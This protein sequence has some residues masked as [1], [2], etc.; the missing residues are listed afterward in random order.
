M[1]VFVIFDEIV[2][3][4]FKKNFKF[5][6]HRYSGN[7]I[8]FQDYVSFLADIFFEWLPGFFFF[9]NLKFSKL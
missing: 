4:K 9:F 5:W 8:G 3:E 6:G 7:S 2:S 1:L